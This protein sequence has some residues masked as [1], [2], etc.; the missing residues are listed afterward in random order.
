METQFIQNL[1][2]LGNLPCQAHSEDQE[3]LK[4]VCI[5]KSCS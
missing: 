4:Y 1:K 3:K 5:L 2:K